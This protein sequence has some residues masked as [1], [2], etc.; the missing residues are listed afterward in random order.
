MYQ[1][2]KQWRS[3]YLTIRGLRYHVRHW[4][5]PGAPQLFLMHG[6]MDC[7]ASFQFLVD[8]L[9]QNWHVV[10]PDWRGF[11]LSQ[12]SGA[13]SYWFPDYL[14]DLDAILLHYS[15][16]T[17]VNLLGHSMGGNI[18]AMYAGVRAHRVVK[19]INLEGFGLPATVPEQAP[20]R[21]AKWLDALLTPHSLK[22]LASVEQVALR[23]QK[24]NPR[25][26]D[27]RAAFLAQHWSR[28][29]PDGEWEILGDAAHKRPSPILYREAEAMACWAK[30]TAPVLWVEAEQTNM[31]QW[32]G[33]KEKARLEIERRMKV[34]PHLT[35]AMLPD[36]GHMLH[37]DQPERLAA[38]VESFLVV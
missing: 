38:M 25:L 32:M 37:H 15:P 14:A 31:W 8:A 23:L 16:E 19:L 26:T 12:S 27:E 6:W 33:E 29:N 11:G 20:A 17:P 2:L 4:G 1:V 13:D 24:T 36:A 5:E 28:Q 34:I 9:A 10:A 7:S 22:R 21:Y 18:V 35:C 3:E 30:T